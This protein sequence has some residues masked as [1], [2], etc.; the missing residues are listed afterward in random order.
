M[1]RYPEIEPVKPKPATPVVH[2]LVHAPKPVVHKGKRK[3]GVYRDPD[4]RR[5]YRREWMAR[6]RALAGLN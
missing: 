3:A 5:A 6:K 2:A 1:I 4:A